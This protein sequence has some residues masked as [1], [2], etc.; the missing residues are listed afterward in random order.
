M[1]LSGA[2]GVCDVTGTLDREQT[3]L[4]IPTT[5]SLFLKDLKFI[6]FSL[7]VHLDWT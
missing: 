3:N 5:N 6:I 4:L 7:K 2:P 1:A